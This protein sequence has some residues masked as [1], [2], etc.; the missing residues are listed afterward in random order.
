MSS[1]TS[2]GHAVPPC[3]PGLQGSQRGRLHCQPRSSLSHWQE[4]FSQDLEGSR[5]CS[6]RD[7]RR[8]RPSSAA[9]W[10][11]VPK[12]WRSHRPPPPTPDPRLQAPHP[13][14]C[15]TAPA[16]HD[17]PPRTRRTPSAAE[18]GR[19]QL[20]SPGCCPLQLLCEH[21]SLRCCTLRL[22]R[23][24]RE[25]R[26]ECGG[27]ASQPRL[28]HSL[29]NHKRCTLHCLLRQT[30]NRPAPLSAAIVSPPLLCNP[31]LPSTPQEGSSPP[32]LWGSGCAPKRNRTRLTLA[33]PCRA[34]WPHPRRP[35]QWHHQQL[36]SAVYQAGFFAARS[37][38]GLRP[39]V[40]SSARL[41]VP[42]HARASG[43]SSVVRRGAKAIGWGHAQNALAIGRVLV[44]WQPLQPSSRSLQ[45]QVGRVRS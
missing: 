7:W 22:L 30:R 6:L 45:F 18:R 1:S 26:V 35:G 25:F 27:P 14:S 33:F 8:R 31:A 4:C 13:R 40:A 38:S 29:C 10:G 15:C 42:S 21:Q 36:P 39:C 16:T 23:Q 19:T 44:P 11:W 3:T 5:R 28:P 17:S 2:H 41:G 34:P 12:Q 9:D 37:G 24:H 32:L 20:P 43:C